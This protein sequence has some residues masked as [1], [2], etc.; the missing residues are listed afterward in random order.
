M[1]QCPAACQ[2]W[3]CHSSRQLPDTAL[4]LQPPRHRTEFTCQCGSKTGRDASQPAVAAC[5]PVRGPQP[6]CGCMLKAQ[7]A[8]GTVEGRSPDAPASSA[9]MW[10]AQTPLVADKVGKA[11]PER[12]RDSQAQAMSASF[13]AARVR[14]GFTH[15]GAMWRSLGSP[16]SHPCGRH[17]AET[18]VKCQTSAISWAT[19]WQA[20]VRLMAP[21]DNLIPSRASRDP[22]QCAFPRHLTKAARLKLR[23]CGAG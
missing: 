22:W 7:S 9:T 1:L 20:I 16:P 17:P 13:G 10:P 6:S 3:P 19:A 21:G 15:P 14:E 2:G 18:N 5:F 4:P 23:I 12:W 11:T 8:E